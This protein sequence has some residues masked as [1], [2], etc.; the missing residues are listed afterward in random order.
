MRQ[1]LLILTQTPLS[2]T[3]VWRIFFFKLFVLYWGIAGYAVIISGEQ[4]SG[5]S[6]TY[7]YPFSPKLPSRLPHNTELYSRSLL[8]AFLNNKQ[9]GSLPDQKES[10]NSRR[11]SLKQYT[12]VWS[13]FCVSLCLV[14]PLQNTKMR[15][16]YIKLKM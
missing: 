1:K 6:H 12:H 7:M 3:Y 9:P 14:P 16:F 15:Y 4:R 10:W 2:G 11:Y 5:L 8:S 13:H